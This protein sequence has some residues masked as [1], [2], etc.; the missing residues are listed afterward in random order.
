MG[1]F[2]PHEKLYQLFPHYCNIQLRGSYAQHKSLHAPKDTF[3][4]GQILIFVTEGFREIKVN[5]F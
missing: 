1:I 5:W 3:M 4:C 2:L